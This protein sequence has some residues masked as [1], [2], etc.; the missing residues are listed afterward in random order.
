MGNKKNSHKKK[1]KLGRSKKSGKI[2]TQKTTVKANYKCV[3]ILE[4]EEIILLEESKITQPNQSCNQ[5]T[6]DSNDYKS[7]KPNTTELISEAVNIH[8]ANEESF[9]NESENANAID[10]K[11]DTESHQIMSHSKFNEKNPELEKQSESLVIRNMSN[12]S[13]SLHNDKIESH[14]DNTTECKDGK[15]GVI[16][17]AKKKVKYSTRRNPVRTVRNTPINLSTAPEDCSKNTN[18]NIE[19]KENKAVK[20]SPDAK[21][22]EEYPVSVHERLDYTP[23]TKQN[24]FFDNSIQDIQNT[25]TSDQS[26]LPKKPKKEQPSSCKGANKKI[27]NKKQRKSASPE[28]IQETVPL[29]SLKPLINSTT[30]LLKQYFIST[31]QNQNIIKSES[32]LS[33]FENKMEILRNQ[34]YLFALVNNLGERG[35]TDK[36]KD[37]NLMYNGKN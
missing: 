4:K 28:A 20:K 33:S 37:L 32:P 31:T 1:S 6:V 12:A 34:A 36:F 16:E 2:D 8:C 30:D 14:N 23:E 27:V 19:E 10:F 7:F 17:S 26:E 11:M 29:D 35:V 15:A 22:S 25:S 18:A 5:F 3:D 21:R 24:Q 9:K 13:R